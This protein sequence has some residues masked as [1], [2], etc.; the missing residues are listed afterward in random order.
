MYQ[1]IRGRLD[2]AR[3]NGLTYS[4]TDMPAILGYKGFL[5]NSELITGPKTVELQ[6]ILL[7]TMP[8]NQKLKNTQGLLLKQIEKGLSVPPAVGGKKRVAPAYN[9]GPW[10]DPDDRLFTDNCY[11]YATNTP[12]AT[13]AQPGDGSNHPFPIPFTDAEMQRAAEFDGL[14]TL[15]EE[16]IPNINGP[17]IIPPAHQATGHLVALVVSPPECKYMPCNHM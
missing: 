16:H 13:F 6:K 11:N 12:T 10:N 4:K 17:F 15:G 8:E 2:A 9:P 5:V 7:Q 1:N 3:K 14:V